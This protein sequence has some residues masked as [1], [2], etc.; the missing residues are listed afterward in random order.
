MKKIVVPIDFSNDSITALNWGL[1]IAKKAEAE[2][3]MLHVNKLKEFASYFSGRQTTENSEDIARNFKELLENVDIKGVNT[4]FEVLEGKVE[5][6]IT[7]YGEENEP[8]LTIIGTHGASGKSEFWAGS[9]AFKVVSHSHCP[10]ITIR[11]DYSN[12]IN[13][14]KI[15]LPIDTDISTRHKV[16]FTID[17]AKIFGAEI[18]ILAA[19]MSSS[20]EMINKAKSYAAQTME[21]IES[22]SSVK[23]SV[24]EAV[25]DNITDMTIEFAKKVGGDLISIMTEQ[26]RAISNLFMGPYA[27]QMIHK[28]PIPVLS[29]HKNPKL[30]GDFSIM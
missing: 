26:E 19:S 14:K 1:E 10:V 11:G 30:E 25:G 3:T 5:E 21:Y 28:S 13:V 22:T 24:E 18:C 4:S 15:I 2:V 23:C 12:G 29:M 27:E 20:P 9:N 6:E 16:P 8:F 17:L 7:N